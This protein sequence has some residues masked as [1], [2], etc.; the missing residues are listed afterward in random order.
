MHKGHP[1]NPALP[2]REHSSTHRKPPQQQN[3]SFGRKFLNAVDPERRSNHRSTTDSNTQG[4]AASSQGYYTAAARSGDVVGTH[5][6]ERDAELLDL[7]KWKLE[8]VQTIEKL[9]AEL[10]HEQEQ[11]TQARRSADHLQTILDN[12]EFFLGPQT[13][14]DEMRT[15]F[16]SIFTDI[17]TWSTHFISGP[18]IALVHQRVDLLDRFQ[19]ILPLCSDRSQLEKYLTSKR[20][21]RL[22][23]RGWAAFIA[24]KRLL[25]T[26]GG[27]ENGKVDAWL[28][29][30]S[31]Q[32]F[33]I[34]EQK[35]RSSGKKSP[36]VAA[37]ILELNSLIPDQV[38]L[39]S[40]V[41]NDWRAL[42]AELLSTTSSER[43]LESWSQPKIR[44]AAKEAMDLLGP[45]APP[46]K[47]Q[48]L[49]QSL[50]NIYRDAVRFAQLSRRQRAMWIVRFPSKPPTSSI[51]ESRL[52]VDPSYM[53]NE[54]DDG[55]EVVD[56][57]TLRQ[58]FVQ[59]AITPALLKRGNADGEHYDRQLTAVPAGVKV[60][61]R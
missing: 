33:S 58:Q 4:N 16:S 15:S 8:H 28:D 25:P 51:G 18:N 2:P 45:L 44:D 57:K 61:S 46:E 59:I 27:G 56:E 21:R 42:T 24:C 48:E 23:V 26:E 22:L 19:Y 43:F 53:R 29:A 34:L 36:I 32:S 52:L 7:R 10:Q 37:S 13:S 50:S 11:T 12:R 40:R 5:L 54:S 55:D 35:I 38:K 1:S 47:V 49:E 60:P 17:K 3:I 14:D 41:L 9:Q 30:A 31:A 6:S 20:K 39:P